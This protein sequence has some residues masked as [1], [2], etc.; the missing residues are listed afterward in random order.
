M[1]GARSA[2]FEEAFVVARYLLGRR[3]TDLGERFAPATAR[4][5][6]L[7]DALASEQ[8]QERA[9]ALAEPLAR[10]LNAAQRGGIE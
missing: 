8:R 7:L 5:R 3:G 6:S 2:H 9:A 1:R 4:A 10:L